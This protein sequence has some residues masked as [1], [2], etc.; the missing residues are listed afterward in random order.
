MAAKIMLV[1][2]CI[3]FLIG[4]IGAVKSIVVTAKTRKRQK[5]YTE[6]NQ[7]Q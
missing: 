4:T 3:F 5:Q 7:K 2:C 6:A 1:A